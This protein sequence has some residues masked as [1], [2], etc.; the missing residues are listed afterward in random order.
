MNNNNGEKNA[1]TH[2][3]HTQTAAAATAPIGNIANTQNSLHTHTQ[4]K[5]RQYCYVWRL[6]NQKR[7]TNAA[8]ELRKTKLH[9]Y[10]MRKEAKRK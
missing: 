2:T 7:R 6:L 8:E 1:H 10:G 9:L 3:Q 5:T 4:N